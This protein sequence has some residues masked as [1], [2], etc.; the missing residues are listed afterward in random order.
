MR[1][2]EELMEIWPNEVCDTFVQRLTSG[3]PNGGGSPSQDGWPLRTDSNLTEVKSMFSGLHLR[4]WVL[5]WMVQAEAEGALV[6]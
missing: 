5:H 2:N 1:I 4:P 6:E 3:R